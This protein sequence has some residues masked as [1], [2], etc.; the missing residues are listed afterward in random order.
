LASATLDANDP[1]ENADPSVNNPDK[2]GFDPFP[3]KI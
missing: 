1:A 2:F 3:F